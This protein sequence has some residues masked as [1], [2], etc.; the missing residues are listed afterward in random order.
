MES[1]RRRGAPAA[2]LVRARFSDY[3][4]L[5]GLGRNGEALAVLQECKAAAEQDRD[6]E[7]LGVIFGALAEVEDA[8]GHQDVAA[9]RSKDSLRY[10]YR[11]GNPSDVAGGHA[12]TRQL[13]RPRRRFPPGRGHAVP[14]GRTPPRTIRDRA[15]RQPGERRSRASAGRTGPGDAPR[16][17]GRTM[18]QDP[19]GTWLRPRRPPRP[20]MARQ[21][22][23]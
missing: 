11:T 8:R 5:L 9:E 19:G 18:R 2:D 1:K 7:M 17:R 21:C 10:L 22:R 6:I 13:H 23:C 20:D 15:G 3:G 14:G 16:Q 4:P 12:Q